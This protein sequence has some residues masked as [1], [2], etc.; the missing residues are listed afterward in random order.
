MEEEGRRRSRQTGNKR[1]K[2][3][4]DAVWTVIIIDDPPATRGTDVGSVNGTG[5]EIGTEICNKGRIAKSAL[6]TVA[7]PAA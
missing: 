3:I 6:T 4:C 1:N 2:R 5:A 7:T